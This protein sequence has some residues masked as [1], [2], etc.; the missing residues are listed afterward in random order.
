MLTRRLVLICLVWCIAAGAAGDSTTRLD[1]AKIDSALGRSG[2]WV[3]GAYL[4]DFFRPNLV[5]T[6]EGVQLVS[7]HVESKATFVGTDDTEMMGDLCALQGELTE[8]IERLRSSNI[9]V[10]GI[11]N[12]FLGESPRL[13]FV[14]FTG[15]G[16]AADLARAFRAALA[17]TTT[18]LGD[19]DAPRM[20]AP[21]DWAKAIQT[22]LGRQGSYSADYGYLAVKFPRAEFP[23][24]PMDF[25][26]TSGLFFQQAPGGKIAAT[27][28]LAVTARELNP[29]LSLL[30]AH[31]FEI[32]GVHNHM[33]DEHPRLFF[34]HFWQVGAPAELASGL[35][36]AVGALNTR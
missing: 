33:I 18:P 17:A 25:W 27:G 15:R 10:T 34:I 35:R 2:V 24:G 5:V 20:S 1:K 19:V 23:A 31:H 36:A 11:H 12:H 8:A 30:T 21:P 32:L 13:M 14:H 6:V 28:D 7:G 4:V 22:A 16:R 29:A 3:N 26:N 9:Q